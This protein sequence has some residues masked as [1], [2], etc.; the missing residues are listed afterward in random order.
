MNRSHDVSFGMDGGQRLRFYIQTFG[1]QMN[2]NDSRLI[3]GLL[4]SA[5]HQPAEGLADA[6]L[7]VV[8][9]CCVRENAENR[10]L[11][12]L[13]SLKHWKEEVPG[14][15][16]AVMGCMAQKSGTAEL[17]QKSYRHIGIVIGTFA[18]AKLPR[19]VEEY[20]ASGERI[21]DTEERYGEEEL[22]RCEVLA[23]TIESG[24][25]AQVNINYGCNNFCSYCIVPYVRGRE[26][27]R[28]VSEIV[29]EVNALTANGVRE[30]QLLG[31]NVN[32]YGRE[33]ENGIDFAY[34]LQQVSKVEGLE[35]IRY[36][37]SHP[38]DFDQRL[39]ETI[40]RLPKVCRHFHLPLQSG[41]D[42]LL[43][44]MN[45]GYQTAQSRPLLQQIRRLFPQATITTDLI[46]GFPGE[47]EKDFQETLDFVCECRFDAAYTFLYS[48]RPGTPAADMPEQ[49][50][51]AVKKERLQRLM[52]IQDPISLA[53]NEQLVG[54]TLS[55][56]VEG[57]SKQNNSMMSGRTDGNKIVI[58]PLQ[59]SARPGD[60]LDIEIRT[61]HTWNL[62]GEPV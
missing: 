53:L 18:G 58:F 36:M 16:I 21:I 60:L 44:Q 30:I 62:Y 48:R 41:C 57:I 25:R 13:G 7:V 59:K 54:R 61:A 5:G 55:V 4:R 49:V 22:K 39:A 26:R 34:L 38:R 11:G 46:V 12:F 8:N 27:S 35:R 31:Q 50:S 9:T 19:Y 47:T 15:I 17:L 51:D 28:S 14:R 33:L 23:P 6:D 20:A 3:A 2:E 24:Y 42:R 32:S 29:D 37:T 56:M 45:R 1:C 40:A 10:A 52:A 43:T